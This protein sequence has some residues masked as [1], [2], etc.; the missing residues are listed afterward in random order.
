[1]HPQ[2][3][4]LI[5]RWHRTTR[6][7]LEDRGAPDTHPK[8]LRAIEAWVEHYNEQRLH[9]GLGYIQPAE[10]FQGDPAARVAQRKRKLAE[11]RQERRNEN[12]N[13]QVSATN[14]DNQQQQAIGT[15]KVSLS[16]NV[17]WSHLN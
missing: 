6:D 8:A 14:H 1:A 17:T 7:A 11:A 12:R 16:G 5:E 13:G 10:Y 2:S 9:A 3:N 4:G 15:Q